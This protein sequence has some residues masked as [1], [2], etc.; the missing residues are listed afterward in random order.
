MGFY[1]H[2]TIILDERKRMER[3]KI[4]AFPDPQ[5][6]IIERYCAEAKQLLDRA[7]SEAEA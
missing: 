2:L 7:T 1:V 5:Q 4:R 6:D 3:L